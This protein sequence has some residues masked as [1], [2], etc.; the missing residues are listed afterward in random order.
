MTQETQR[1][2]SSSV[3]VG[4]IAKTLDSSFAVATSVPTDNSVASAPNPPTKKARRTPHQ[5]QMDQAERAHSN[6]R[7]QE[8]FKVALE[9]VKHNHDKFPKGHPLHQ[10]GCIDF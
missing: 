3:S 8:S 1:K 2:R 10:I 6:Q 4:S 5:V 7:E 9:R